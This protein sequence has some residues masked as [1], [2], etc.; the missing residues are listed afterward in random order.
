M[1]ALNKDYTDD[2][3]DEGVEMMLRLKAGDDAAMQELAARYTPLI[4]FIVSQEM[5][6]REQLDDIIQ[7]V[8]L[9]VF[10]NRSQYQPSSK[11]S[12]WLGTITR[13]YVK[14]AKRNQVVR[15]TLAVEFADTAVAGE[16]D[17]PVTSSPPFMDSPLDN[18]IADE[19]C[20][21]LHRA[22]DLLPITYKRAVQL[23]CL[24]CLSYREAAAE[25]EITTAALK[26]ILVRA[27]A[28]L[29]KRLGARQNGMA[30]C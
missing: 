7:E 17:Y 6:A 15:R 19:E 3:F 27:K 2:S 20:D 24:Q 18:A 21:L 5:N 25:M 22:I 23:V 11:F 4:R 8:M 29:K 26:A 28:Q 9:R 13:N 14:N 1:I 16:A 30:F 12:S 10:R